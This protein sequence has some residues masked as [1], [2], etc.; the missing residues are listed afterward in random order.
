[1]KRALM[2]LVLAI[3]ACAAESPTTSREQASTTPIAWMLGAWHCSAMYHDVPPFSA[4]TADVAYAFTADP[5]DPFTVRATYAEAASH[6]DPD[7]LTIAEVWHF[8]PP[9]ESGVG[10][11]T[12][13]SSGSDG[14]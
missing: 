9:F 14:T 11:F 12:V 4:H 1:M 6:E 13:E 2:T 7:P 8:S 5:D 10:A 3:T